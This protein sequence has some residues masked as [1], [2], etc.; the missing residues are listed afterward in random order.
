[1]SRIPCP[2]YSSPEDIQMRQYTF[3]LPQTW[4]VCFLSNIPDI[5]KGIQLHQ[6]DDPNIAKMLKSRPSPHNYII[7]EHILLHL[8]SGKLIGKVVL[9]PKINEIIFKYYHEL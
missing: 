8:A 5:F 9:P 3:R 2:V 7:K 1:M 4:T 6:K